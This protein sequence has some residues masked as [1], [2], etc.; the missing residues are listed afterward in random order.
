M[1]QENIFIEEN[2]KDYIILIG[3]NKNDNDL[4]IK[5]SQPNDIWFHFADISGPHIIL[6]SNGDLIPKKILESNCCK[7]I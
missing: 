5:Q 6:Q 1:K 2:S 7:I 4:I 3:Q